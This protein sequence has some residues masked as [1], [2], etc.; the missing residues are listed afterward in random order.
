MGEAPMIAWTGQCEAVR[1]QVQPGED[2]SHLIAGAAHRNVSARSAGNWRT[3]RRWSSPVLEA[4]EDQPPLKERET[5]TSSS[6]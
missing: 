1:D 3:G 6:G 5:I 4:L 2:M